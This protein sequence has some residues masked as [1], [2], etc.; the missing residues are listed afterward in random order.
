M[1]KIKALAGVVAS[2]KDLE[3]GEV[4]EVSE[5]DAKYLISRGKA[6]P[7]SEAGYEG[8]TVAQ[9]KSHAEDNDISLDGITKKADIIAAIE[10]AEEE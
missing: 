8:M 6:E 5:R 9:L 3:V 1:T 10:L 4:Y 7:A 2:G